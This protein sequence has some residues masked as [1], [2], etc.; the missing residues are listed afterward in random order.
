MPGYTPHAITFANDIAV[1]L[2]SEDNVTTFCNAIE[3][4]SLAL[5]AK[6][7]DDKT[8]ML[9][10]GNTTL[11]PSD[12]PILPDRA[13]IRYLGIYFSKDGIATGHMEG[14]LIE[15]MQAQIQC[16]HDRQFSLYG[17]VLLANS[18]LMAK[19]WYTARITPFS[20]SF[21]AQVFDQWL[22]QKNIHSSDLLAIAAPKRI[23]KGLPVY[24]DRVLCTWYA[25]KG[26]GPDETFNCSIDI[27]L[28]L[29]F[30]HP[31]VYLLVEISAAAWKRLRA[32]KFFTPGDIFER[33]EPT[34]AA[35]SRDDP[36]LQ[37]YV[38]AFGQRRINLHPH[39]IRK[40]LNYPLDPDRRAVWA[41][42][43]LGGV[44]LDVYLPRQGR[45]TAGSMEVVLC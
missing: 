14:Q 5:N 26:K 29:P 4:H 34:G 17:R 8:E 12:I 42:A 20:N 32:N 27:I 11:A 36:L 35:I 28:D 15:K 25:L 21:N 45:L 33:Y 24:W 3:L 13:V 43:Q 2:S 23:P 7:N 9:R 16:W 19:L 38:L 10:I 6:L 31:A 22:G 40:L 39:V 18:V 1:T 37:P 44:P 30:D 41:Y